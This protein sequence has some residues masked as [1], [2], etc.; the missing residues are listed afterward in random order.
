MDVSRDVLIELMAVNFCCK[1][2]KKPGNPLTVYPRKR[3]S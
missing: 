1:G 3:R 2:W